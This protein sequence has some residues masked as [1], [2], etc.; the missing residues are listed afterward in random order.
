[1]L[2]NSTVAYYQS[3][4]ISYEGIEDQT[5]ETDNAEQLLTAIEL[6]KYNKKQGN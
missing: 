2:N 4:L 1:M 3:F 6:E 5:E